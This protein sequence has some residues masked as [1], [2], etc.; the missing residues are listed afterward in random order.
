MPE[1]STW[2]SLFKGWEGGLN[3]DKRSTESFLNYIERIAYIKTYIVSLKKKKNIHGILKNAIK[4][5]FFNSAV[6]HHHNW[7]LDRNEDFRDWLRM[8]FEEEEPDT[9]FGIYKAAQVHIS[10]PL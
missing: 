3:C 8:N 1:M 9:I 10:P 6:I 7:F 2:S 4:F 5:Y